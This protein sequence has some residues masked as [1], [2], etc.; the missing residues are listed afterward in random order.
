MS[1][2]T[3]LVLGSIGLFFVFFSLWT[4]SENPFFKEV[5]LMLTLFSPINIIYALSKI[6][7]LNSGLGNYFTKS[8]IIYGIILFVIMFYKVII[9]LI[10]L[11]REVVKWV[12]NKL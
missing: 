5:F 3:G 9:Y 6:E 11:F 1:W 2:E 7:A 12:K 4:K 10:N 8:L